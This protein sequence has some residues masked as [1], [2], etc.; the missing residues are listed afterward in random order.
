MTHNYHEAL[1]GYHPDQILTDG[2]AECE[3]RSRREDHGIGTLDPQRFF[4]AWARAR[5]WAADGL[6]SVS[7]AELPLLAVLSAIDTQ[8]GGP[9]AARCGAGRRGHVVTGLV[10]F[11]AGRLPGRRRAGAA[12]RPGPAAVQRGRRR[13][14]GAAA[15]G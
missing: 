5:E 10:V 8:L 7:Q 9:R 1:P 13:R 11:V 14:A 4:R 2:C 3:W 12:A 15:G 6:D